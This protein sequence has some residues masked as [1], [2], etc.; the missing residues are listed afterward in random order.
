MAKS[1]T[2]AKGANNVLKTLIGFGLWLAVGVLPI[3]AELPELRLAMGWSGTAGTATVHDCVLIERADDDYTE[4]TGV[5]VP[6][7]RPAE[8]VNVK[9]PPESDE[10]ETFPAR[11]QADGEWARPTDVKGKLGALAIPALGVL[12]LVPMPWVIVGAVAGRRAPGKVAM[13]FMA[14]V[15]CIPAALFV[16]GMIA[17][18]L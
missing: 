4:C 1:R 11:L 6:N 16:I 15:A 12:F 9:L 3:V 5:F 13:R 2:S 10:G 17:V 8:S 7:D 14:V 18:Q